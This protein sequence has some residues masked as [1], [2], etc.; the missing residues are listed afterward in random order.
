M[1]KKI[2]KAVRC[3]LIRDGKVVV[4]KYNEGQP[5]EG[6]YDIPGGKIED[7]E[8]PEQAAIREMKEETGIIVKNL[9][10]RGK[11]VADNPNKIFEFEVFFAEDFEGEPQNFEENTS[12][13][14][15]IEELLKK[16]KIF[17]N[18]MVLDRFFINALI[19]EKSCFE[20]YVR[21][22]EKDK[23]LETRYKLNE[24]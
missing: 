20:M 2:V 24:R 21:L 22:D 23:I 1:D 18:I 15:E 7:G 16:E 8:T 10:R 13:W 6:Y 12:E 17:S 11:F 14:V 5:T 19:D 4:T 9:K 3:Y